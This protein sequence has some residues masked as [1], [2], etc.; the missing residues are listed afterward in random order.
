M[1]L[2]ITVLALLVASSVLAEEGWKEESNAKGVVIQSRHRPGSSLKEFRA[3]GAIDATPDEV[4]SVIDD[5]ESY[6]RFMPY[7]A[8]ARVLKREKNSAVL[9]QRLSLP[10]VSD[11]DYTLVSKH[12]TSVGP[13]GQTHRVHWEA[14]NDL[15]PVAKPGVVRV[16]LCEGGWLLEPKGANSTRATY[17]IYT[18]SGGAIPAFIANN[19]CRV[20][21]RKL[22]E[23]IRKQVKDPKYTSLRRAE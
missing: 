12:E 8:E 4:F 15:G 16:N 10:L 23:A 2:R 20:A 3:V 13:E 21:I 18:D 11:R 7:V 1:L 6:A 17:L 19:G 14:A 22:F 5:A 9:Y